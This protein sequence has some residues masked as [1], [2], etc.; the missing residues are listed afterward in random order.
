MPQRSAAWAKIF[1]GIAVLAQAIVGTIGRNLGTLRKGPLPQVTGQRGIPRRDMPV[2]RPFHR[3]KIGFFSA[4]STKSGL[5]VLNVADTSPGMIIPRT[6]LY[7]A[8]TCCQIASSTG[9]PFS[10]LSLR[11]SAM[12]APGK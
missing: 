3:M 1:S 9:I 8:S 4:A 2:F 11:T 6:S 5:S 12:C 10:M 7:S